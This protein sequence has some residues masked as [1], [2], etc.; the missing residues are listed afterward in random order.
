[1]ELAFRKRPQKSKAVLIAGI[2]LAACLSVCLLVYVVFNALVQPGLVQYAEYRIQSIATDA[3]YL[4]IETAMHTSDDSYVDILQEN[5]QV[6]YIEMNS[7]ELN[8]LASRVST[9]VQDYINQIGVQGVDIPFGTAS[10]IPL[11]AGH[12]PNILLKF[13]P[14]GTSQVDFSTEFRSAGINQT[15]HRVHMVVRTDISMVLPGVARTVTTRV[16]MTVAEHV[17]VG[18]VPEGYAGG[19]GTGILN[20]TP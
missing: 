20:L 14:E 19:D 7:R 2:I 9:D 17:I 16:D 8:K 3:I 6:Y 18:N 11:L 5:G 12:G 15:L 4:A 13:R 1:M 10:G